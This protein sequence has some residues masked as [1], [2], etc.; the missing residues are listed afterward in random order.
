MGKEREMN[1]ALKSVRR[2]KYSLEATKR[3]IPELQNKIEEMKRELEKEQNI[4][5]R[6]HTKVYSYIIF[7]LYL[8][9]KSIVRGIKM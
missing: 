3:S 4:A 8:P 1:N 6:Q 5:K 2:A 9:N 7:K